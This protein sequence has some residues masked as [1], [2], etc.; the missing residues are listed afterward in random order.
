MKGNEIPAIHKDSKLFDVLMLSFMTVIK[1]LVVKL[2]GIV[3]S[4]WTN[5]TQRW[6]PLGEG[7]ICD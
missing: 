5:F 6:T 3:I 7:S 1:V 2:T 4:A